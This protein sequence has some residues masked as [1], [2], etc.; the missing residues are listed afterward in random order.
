MLTECNTFTPPG[1]F[2]RRL[3]Q[4]LFEA[5]AMHKSMLFVLSL[6]LVS[7]LGAQPADTVLVDEVADHIRQHFYDPKL[8]GA[9]LGALQGDARRQIAS[10]RR[11]EEKAAVLNRMLGALRTSH[12]AFYSPES[13]AYYEI[14]GIFSPDDA[15]AYDGIGAETALLPEGLFVRAA[16]AGH[17]ARKAGLR[18]GDRIL[19]VDGERYHEIHSFRGKKRVTMRVQRTADPASVHEITV[20][21]VSIRSP[22][23]FEKA[24][25][26]S[27][28]VHQ[29]RGKKI[30]YVHVWSYA[31]EHYQEALEDVVLRGPLKDCDA[32]VLDIR[33]GWGG[34]KPNYL[35]LFNREVPRFAYIGRD[36]VTSPVE[37]QWRKPVALLVN[38]GS[39]SG[40]EILAQ[41]FKT[42]NL[43]PV[44]GART[45]G[46]CVGGRP[47]KLKS[48]GILYLAVA[49]VTV[50]E[51]VIEGIGVEPD[52]TVA[53]PLPYSQGSDPQKARAL[54][55]IRER[56]TP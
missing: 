17:P 16:W 12:T 38:E 43:G 3:V 15:P 11:W 20:E 19:A 32:L 23:A 27:A 14:Q 5:L 29:V 53:Q 7:A 41:G 56:L 30:G 18:P 49:N 35:N 48:G 25:R 45:A 39:R 44:V 33:D 2:P 13:R 52:V 54:Q 8:A 40:K 34:A 36:G 10:A 22:A 26:E 31:G 28:E 9:D 55:V 50:D 1:K 4:Q 21:V 37:S 24:L 51:Q 6:T 46:A 42:Y 47:F